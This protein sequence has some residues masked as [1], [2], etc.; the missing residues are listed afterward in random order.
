M[1]NQLQASN[2]VDILFGLCTNK[3]LFRAFRAALGQS[4]IRPEL[5]WITEAIDLT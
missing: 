4:N 3:L 2:S 1:H 5:N